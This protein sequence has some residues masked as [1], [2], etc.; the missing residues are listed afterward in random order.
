MGGA[1]VNMGDTLELHDDEIQKLI[2]MGYT[3]EYLD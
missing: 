2:D 1:G 3:V